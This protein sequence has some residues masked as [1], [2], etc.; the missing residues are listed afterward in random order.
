MPWNPEKY[1]RFKAIRYQPFFDLM[2]LISE[3]GLRRAADIGCGTGE[4]TGIL[5]ENFQE[6]TFLGIDSSAEMLSGS[7]KYENEK[8]KFRLSTIEAFADTDEKWDLIF[9]NAAL[10]WTDDHSGLFPRLIS[11]LNEGG[12]FAVQMPVQ[13]ENLLNKLLISLVQEKPYVDFLQGW[14]RESPVLSMDEYA[15][16]LFQ[17]GLKDI[18]VIQKVY[19]IIADA[20][21][22]LFDFIAGTALI[23]YLDKMP[24]AEQAGFTGE[25]K[26]RIGRA[27]ESFPA[28][29]AFKRLLLY[30]RKANP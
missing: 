26:R 21:E 6:A 28:I 7:T 17:G 3:K 2:N 5:S 23:P 18:Q 30:G 27:F 14:K 19:P 22:E 15:Q 24:E 13:N 9:S 12:Q 8:L 1:N 16:I 10:Q 25:F 4:Q 20:P 29:Y 11:K